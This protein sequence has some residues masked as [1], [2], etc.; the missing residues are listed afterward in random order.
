MTKEQIQ[1][2]I[3]SQP[4]TKEQLADLEAA[5]VKASVKRFVIT[6]KNY[7]KENETIELIEIFN[8]P[9]NPCD[10]PFGLTLDEIEEMYKK[11]PE[12]FEKNFVLKLVKEERENEN[13]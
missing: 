9:C 7:G 13:S 5:L 8:E 12:S 3:D 4:W 11:E 10:K 2:L 6:Q 1:K